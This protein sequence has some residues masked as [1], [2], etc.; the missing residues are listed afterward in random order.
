MKITSL[1]F[2]DAIQPLFEHLE[3]I[4]TVHNPSAIAIVLGTAVVNPKE[5]FIIKIP[6]LRYS[7]E[8][9]STKE[10]GDSV[11]QTVRQL[12]MDGATIWTSD[13]CTRQFH[14]HCV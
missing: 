14:S 1:Q 12:I 9:I 10:I 13:L 7:D 8:D 5:T 3:S 11:R 2:C 6:T 4:L